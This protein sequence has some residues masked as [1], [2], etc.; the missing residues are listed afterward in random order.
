MKDFESVRS[1][2]EISGADLACGRGL[3]GRQAYIGMKNPKKTFANDLEVVFLDRGLN[4][5]IFG[6]RD[7]GNSDLGPF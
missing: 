1:V 6:K 4:S 5:E 2:S 7:S 3:D